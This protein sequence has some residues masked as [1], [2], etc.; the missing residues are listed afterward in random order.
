MK[1]TRYYYTILRNILY[2]ERERESVKSGTGKQ[3]KINNTQCK[4]FSNNNLLWIYIY[5]SHLFDNIIVI[6]LESKG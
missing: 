2:K 3:K 5:V 4:T 6:Y 1:E